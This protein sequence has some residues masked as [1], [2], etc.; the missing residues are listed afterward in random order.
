MQNVHI[1]FI[2]RM[3]RDTKSI[4]NLYGPLT[5]QNVL[6]T[7]TPDYGTI[8]TQELIDS[9][10]MFE[11]AGLTKQNLAD[12]AYA[13]EQIRTILT[14]AMPSLSVLANLP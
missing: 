5:Q 6:W 3:S 13:L 11:S 4:L 12:V 14:N 7:G 2:N 8:I 1:D 10:V 9:V